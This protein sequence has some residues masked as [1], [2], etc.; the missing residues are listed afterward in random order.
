L[1]TDD[2]ISDKDRD[3]E[4]HPFRMGQASERQSKDAQKGV[5][6]AIIG[7]LTPPNIAEHASGHTKPTLRIAPGREQGRDPV[8]YLLTGDRKTSGSFRHPGTSAQERVL[9]AELRGQHRQ[10]LPLAHS[11]TGKH[12]FRRFCRFKQARHDHRRKWQRLG[13]VFRNI[14]N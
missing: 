12:D 1:F 2:V 9:T 6:G 11:K 10:K 3:G 5:F 14:G 8:K 13:S 7:V 4:K